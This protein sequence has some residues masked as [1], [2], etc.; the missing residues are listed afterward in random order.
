MRSR[1]E[2]RFKKWRTNELPLGTWHHIHFLTEAS[3]GLKRR[4]CPIVIN[5]EAVKAGEASK[6][7][8]L[9]DRRGSFKKV[10]NEESEREPGG[11]STAE[12]EGCPEE[13]VCHPRGRIKGRGRHR[14]WKLEMGYIMDGAER[15]SRGERW[16]WESSSEWR[17]P[18]RKLSIDAVPEP[19]AGPQIWQFGKPMASFTLPGIMLLVIYFPFI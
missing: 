4:G 17:E 12:K 3:W 1:R 13:N 7:V 5:E 15:K 9:W 10:G 18:K 6:E 2:K 19:Q 11:G 14:R 16:D 8:G